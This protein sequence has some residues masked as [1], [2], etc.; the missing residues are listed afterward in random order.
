MTAIVGIVLYVATGARAVL[1][2]ELEQDPRRVPISAL[3]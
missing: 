2:G 3:Y 1:E